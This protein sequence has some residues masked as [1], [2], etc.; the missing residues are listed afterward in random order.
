MGRAACARRE[1][2]SRLGLFS[3]R[4]PAGPASSPS[5]PGFLS[6][7]PRAAAR[8]ALAALLLAGAGTVAAPASADVLVSNVGK[9]DVGRG[10]LRSF[11]QAQAFTTGSNTAGYTVSS[12]EIDIHRSGTVRH[13]FTVAI[14][15]NSSGAPDASLGTLTLSGSL[16]DGV[17]E[18]TT[19]GI[20]LAASTTY[21]V[22][23]DADSG[24]TGS[25]DAIE[26]TASN[27]EDTL[28]PATG[29]TIGNSSL[30]RN[31][32]STDPWT[33]WHES[34]RIRINGTIK[35]SSTNAAPTASNGT[36]E[37]KEDED[38]T[39]Q[40]SDFNFSDTD[41]DDTELA[42]VKIVSV[43]TAGH[44]QLEGF[45]VTANQVVTKTQLDNNQLIFTPAEDAH[46]SPYTTFTFKVNDGEDDSADTYTMTIDIDSVPDVTGVSIT[47]SPRS[48]GETPPDT[49]G[50]GETIEI[51]AT[52][53]EAVTVT[54]DPEIEF[55]MA[56][57]SDTQVGTDAA[58]A[59]GSGST[60]LVFEY[61]VQSS[62]SDDNG[63]KF[64]AND[65]DL[66]SND[67]IQ[68]SDQNDA[69]TDH[70]AIGTQ[71]G[72]KIDGSLTPPVSCPD[73]HP[74]S[75]F[76]SACLT[77]GRS[78]SDYGYGS[79]FGSLSDTGFTVSSTNYTVSKLSHDSFTGLTLT[80]SA[81]PGSAANKW[82]LQVGGTSLNLADATKS[83]R[84][85]TWGSGLGDATWG[86]SK[87][88]R[89]CSSCC[90]R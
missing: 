46:G 37:T 73:G 89:W 55:Q 18:W 11:D 58:Y 84:S 51:T 49:Y 33:T 83:S 1:R 40:V 4:R 39:F 13:S 63:I 75:A 10:L 66:D 77:V 41:A 19:T 28:T 47:S 45:D 85:Y 38:Y 6:R 81:D 23:I 87:A 3:L 69:D 71:S 72:H 54:G 88:R 31:Y 22:V 86:S 12:V 78:S 57:S 21:F 35:S 20:D 56:D 16:S 82:T 30:Y 67:K 9:S 2:Q 43:E 60:K 50:E 24:Q 53:D 8:L 48:G 68:D 34:K 26:N 90:P 5:F 32:A 70:A 74:A 59:R 17:N 79:G 29:W 27:D 44:L 52:F 36:V 76:W 61:E 14:W 64:D 15:S 42:S 65:I 80:L 25:S 7:L 62:D